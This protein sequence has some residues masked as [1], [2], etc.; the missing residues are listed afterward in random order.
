M[1][2]AMPLESEGGPEPVVQVIGPADG[3][4]LER[5][6]RTLAAK[7]PYAEF[8]HWR[9]KPR[10][11]T[12]LAYYINYALFQSPSGL[13][14]VVFFTHPDESH[15]SLERALRADACVAM[16]RQYA[17]Q[18]SAQG[19]RAVIHIPMS[20]DSYR[21]RP[22]LVL[23]VIGRLEHPRKGRDLVDRIRE[24]PFVEVI[25][26]EGHTPRGELRDVYERLDYV[27]IPATVE[28]G[29]MCLLEGLAMGKPVIAPEGVGMVPEFAPARQIRLYPKGDASAL[30]KLVTDCYREKETGSRSIEDRSWDGWAERHHHFF[31]QLLRSRGLHPPKP[32]LGFRFGM[33]RELAVPLS[34]L[35]TDPLE[36]AIDRAARH[37]FYGRYRLAR[38]AIEES[39]RSY[40]FVEPLLA[41]I[42]TGR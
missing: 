4:I 5:L 1:L 18:L 32:A 26:T 39:R 19:V 34:L 14:D 17:D 22:R 16:A 41:G 35:D 30:V 42:P 25:T 27:L 37:L 36:E 3:W 40:P 15:Q 28:G 11:S 13:I 23:G 20:F 10:T 8:V 7:L 38:E 21:F 9:P 6:A 24:L 33:L 31:V 12:L 29:P 2:E